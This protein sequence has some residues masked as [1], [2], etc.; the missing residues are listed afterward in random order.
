MFL[1]G[2]LLEDVV[3]G[4][5]RF[6][7]VVLAFALWGNGTAAAIGIAITRHGLFEIDRIISRTVTYA[8]VITLL[9]LVYVGGLAGL[10]TMLDTDSPLAVAA[11]TL[12]AAALFTPLRRRVQTAVDHR[13]NRSRYDAERVIDRFSEG[14][15]DEVDPERVVE[16]WVSVVN[17]TMKPVT[18]GLWV[19]QA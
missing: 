1:A 16:G 12:A 9:G 6:D 3:L 11:S 15:R 17:E 18:S 10:T 8:I 2:N 13:F 4:T 14:L 19:R 7:P 5:G